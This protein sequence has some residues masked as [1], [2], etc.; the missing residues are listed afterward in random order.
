VRDEAKDL[1]E[2]LLKSSPAD[3]L[4][5]GNDLENNFQ[6]LKDHAFFHG[7]CFN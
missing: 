5:A 7:V 2:Q 1:I 3:R 4:G 6:A